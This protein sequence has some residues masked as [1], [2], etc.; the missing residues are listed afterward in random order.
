L[1]VT[2][3]RSAFFGALA[4]VL[5]IHEL[6]DI[7]LPLLPFALLL[8]HEF[9]GGLHVQVVYALFS[10][11]FDHFLFTDHALTVQVS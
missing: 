4:Q 2:G 10:L 7:Q 1:E 5:P 8:V 11:Q 3:A 9:V 6:I